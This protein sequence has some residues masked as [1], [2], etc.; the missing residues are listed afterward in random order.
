M[1]RSTRN[2]FT[3]TELLVVIAIIAVLIALFLPATRRVRDGGA[4]TQINNNLKQLALG[5]HSY[6]DV[7]KQ[8][9]PAT[10]TVFTS[11][12]V[13]G[14]QGNSL[15]LSI[16]LLPYV[17]QFPLFKQ[18]AAGETVKPAQIPPY[19]APLDISTSDFIGVQNFAGNVR[20]FTDIGVKTSFDSP[21]TGLDAFHGSCTTK[22]KDTFTDGTSN[23]IMFATRFANHDT[24]SS[25]GVVNCSAYDALLGA[26]NSAF[27]GVIPM[28]GAP[29]QTSTGGWQIA[30]TLSQANCQF[31]AVAHSFGISGLQV[32][33]ADASAR[34]IYPTMT[35]STWNSVLQPNDGNALGTDW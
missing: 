12:T 35:A 6:H 28:K 32:V 13:S 26:D 34:V 3:I 8:F 15:S 1:S 33:L 30:P 16:H 19:T 7:H 31:G 14:S 4:R 21:V 17:E 20:V 2:G 11:E 10:G 9:P 22:L 25:Q 24:M 23:T 18:Y 29:S 5:V 27:F